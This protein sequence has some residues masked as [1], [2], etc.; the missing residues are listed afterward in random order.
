MTK[1]F[2]CPGCGKSLIVD[3]N[4]NDELAGGKD[5][6]CSHCNGHSWFPITIGKPIFFSEAAD[7]YGQPRQLTM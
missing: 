4:K 6:I 1:L 5:E 3:F 7:Q 2:C